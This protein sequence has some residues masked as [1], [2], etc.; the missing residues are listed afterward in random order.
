[1]S[2]SCCNSNSSSNGMSSTWSE[3]I[4]LTGTKFNE[5]LP[6]LTVGLVITV[7]LQQVKLPTV[8]VRRFLT[9]TSKDPTFFELVSLCLMASLLGL[10]TPLCSC[11]A[12]PL[13]IGLS[14]AGASPAAVVS[15]LTAAQSAGLDSAAI[16]YGMLGGET[17]FFRLAGAIILS[18]GAGV[19]V[20]RTTDGRTTD[21]RTT[22]ITT[23]KTDL[24]QPNK[25]TVKSRSEDDDEKNDYSYET[26]SS[27]TTS[28]NANNAN[29][30]DHG[31]N[32]DDDNNNNNSAI[33]NKKYKRHVIKLYKSTYNLF[34]EIWFV[35]LIGIFISVLVQDR[36]SASDM[37]KGG[38]GTIDKTTFTTSSTTT[39]GSE[40]LSSPALVVEEEE[41][42]EYV[43][44]P[45][46]WD[47]EEDGP[48]PE[49]P[50]IN[51]SSITTTAT[52]FVVSSPPPYQHQDVLTRATI[53]VGS[54]PFQ[55]CEHGVVSF[56]AA[57]QKSGASHGTAHAFLLMAP[58][59]NIAT[60]GA[61]LKATGGLDRFA[62]LRSAA[63]ISIL[64]FGM[65][66]VFDFLI[67]S[68]SGKNLGEAVETFVLPEW[69]STMSIWICQL[70][71]I[72][73]L[74]LSKHIVFFYCYIG[75]LCTV[76]R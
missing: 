24:Q 49:P 40:P 8:N 34:N 53:V 39:S 66:Y 5:S 33:I 59:T 76:V 41:A 16:T 65:S 21:G 72:Q 20:G 38:V 4:I 37:A 60:L 46:W 2:P 22:A 57:L 52:S 74:L 6:W 32:D 25:P 28:D 23:M 75:I 15:F 55:L 29:E 48:Y 7:I 62:P 56:A 11:G 43:P 3:I 12:I 35:L 47:E 13:S 26:N 18:I 14:S 70:F 36:F 9:F 58:A 63:A 17:A 69:W 19:A 73:S 44:Q 67:T 64:A 50:I 1:M 51:P 54:L 61:V 45:D 31:D 68:E 27:T 10:A 42:E 30:M 71:I